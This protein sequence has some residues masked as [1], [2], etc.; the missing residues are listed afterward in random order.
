[1]IK[2]ESE[3]GAKFSCKY[4]HGLNR[5]NPALLSSRERERHFCMG[6]TF[7]DSN[8]ATSG[9]IEVGKKRKAYYDGDTHM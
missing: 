2:G 9:L 3:R 4:V 5:C 6:L 1:M 8:K 7:K